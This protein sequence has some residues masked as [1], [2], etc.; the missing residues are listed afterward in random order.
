VGDQGGPTVFG[1]FTD[2]QAAIYAYE[3]LRKSYSD[4]FLVSPS[5]PNSNDDIK[6][7]DT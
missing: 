1:L 7:V 5:P 2:S 6:A 3:E 4:V